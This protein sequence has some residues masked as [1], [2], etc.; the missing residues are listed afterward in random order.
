MAWISQYGI[1]FNIYCNSAVAPTLN[2]LVIVIIDLRLFALCFTAFFDLLISLGQKGLITFLLK[3]GSN[4][5]LHR[6]IPYSPN[7]LLECS[8]SHPGGVMKT[9]VV[10]TY[11]KRLMWPRVS[12]L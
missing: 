9:V 5:G 1:V 11:Q 7:K 4:S 12:K 6:V 10:V 8:F 3:G 2:K